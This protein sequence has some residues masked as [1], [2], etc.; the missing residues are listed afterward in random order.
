MLRDAKNTLEE[1]D[2]S[3]ALTDKLQA[4]SVNPISNEVEDGLGTDMRENEV[5]LWSNKQSMEASEE[6]R[7]PEPSHFCP[8]FQFMEANT[9]L[10]PFLLPL[11]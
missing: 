9:I 11:V 1:V 5:R 7:T 3:M 10:K 4:R 6:L 8:A 2:V